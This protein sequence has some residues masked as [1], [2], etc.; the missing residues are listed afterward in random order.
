M[1]ASVAPLTSR[2]RN[3]NAFQAA[4]ILYGDW[5][6]SKAYVIGLAFA[7]SGYS[8]FWLIAAVSILTILVGINYIIICKHNPYGGGAYASVRHRSEVL[9]F[10]G[11]FFL[12]ADYLVTAALSALSAFSYLNVESPEKWT[13]FAIMAVG[14]I[15]FFGPKHT[16]SLAFLVSIPTV[17]V[18]FI[19]GFLAIPHL[20]VAIHSLKPLEGGVVKIWAE[21]VSI[22]VALSGIEA[23]ANTTGVMKLD[24]GSTEANP[25]VY[26]TATPA[27]VSVMIEVS[28]F[29]ALFGL[30]A[31]ALPHLE[32]VAGEVIAPGGVSIR[33]SMLR[34]MGEFFGTSSFGPMA[35]SVFGYL[36]SIVFCVLLLSAV[37]TA[38]GA[39]SSL[40]FVMSRDGAVPFIFQKLN[41]YG[42]PIYSLL[43][44]TVIPIFL[45]A[46]ID[47]VA[48]LAQL[49][50]VGFVGAIATNLGS[51]ATDL[52]LGLSKRE[53][54]FMFFTFL[55]ML[56]IEITLF[57]DKPKA[58]N[59]AFSVLAVGLFLRA[60]VAEQIQKKQKPRS[61]D[62]LALQM[63]S[64][65]GA[66]FSGTHPIEKTFH[67]TLRAQPLHELPQEENESFPLHTGPIMCAVTHVGK[68]LDFA[69]QE[70]LKQI[71]PLYVLFLREQSVLTEEDMD[72]TWLD[73]NDA[74]EI[75]DY[76]KDRLPEMSIRFMYLVSD[77]P[78]DSIVK[79]AHEFKVSRLILGMPR[80]NKLFQL[81][82]GNVVFG[83][84]KILPE[85]IDLIVIW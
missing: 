42:V 61:L 49:Y 38:I 32:V 18:V 19:L 58:R 35:G 1:T 75:V 2:P 68:T 59:Y 36:I 23:I 82:R 81:L 7:I 31:H 74:C 46:S 48:G 41:R 66:I 43:I 15:N 6:T 25:S 17:I 55:I 5:G 53:R 73:D 22:I 80:R 51:T 39:L 50:A 37:N 11:A 65:K 10:V 77:S 44:A 30:A 83:V 9:A 54:A 29:T 67:Y 14:A 3:V 70:S 56:S 34:Y 71:Q 85:E 78:P 52:S 64:Q 79:A 33:D 26:N 69:L 16:G 84:S 20:G 62:Q 40:L 4:A 47:D 21:F 12:I 27:I 60:L 24:K 28:F 57:I 63:P 13:I 76:L 72:R 45:V 8:S